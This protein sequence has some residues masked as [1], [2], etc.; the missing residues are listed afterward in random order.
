MGARAF[1]KRF[2]FE[3]L[4][5]VLKDT[6]LR[7]PLSVACC[8]A[9]AALTVLRVHEAKLFDEDFA[10]RAMLFLW[11]GL[12][13]FTALRLFVESRGL[14][15][16]LEFLLA[17]LGGALLLALSFLPAHFS[18]MHLFVSAALSL[19][20]LF[21]PYVGRAATEDSVWYYNYLNGIS[22]VI[23]GLSTFILCLGLCAVVGSMD[24]LIYGMKFNGRVYGDIWIFGGMFFG[25]LAFM[26][27]IPRRFDF[28]KGECALLP[29]VHFI[30]NYLVVPLVLIYTWVLYAYFLKIAVQWELPK[31]QLAYMVTGFGA[32]GIAAHLAVFPM[33]ETG[34]ML[35]RQFHRYFYLLLIVPVIL[36]A[37]GLY[38]RISQ[39]G[40]TEERYTIG[41][42][43][44]WLAL[45]AAWHIAKPFRAHIKHV[46]MVLAALFLLAAAGPWGAVN[47]STQS[48]SARLEALLAQAGVLAQG[49]VRKTD[50]PVPFE[51]RK[52]ISGVL[53]YM[54]DGKE[55]AVARWLEPFRAGI[56]EKYKITDSERQDCS[57][58]FSGC[59]EWSYMPERL[60]EAWGMKYVS[61]W[62]DSES[63]YV[64]ISPANYD[65]LE[66]RILRVSPYAY[67][68]RVNA[69]LHNGEWREERSFESGAEKMKVALALSAE[70][71]FTL[72]LAD[73]RSAAFPLQPLAQQLYAEKLVSVPSERLDRLTLHADSG[74]FPAEAQVSALR[75]RVAADQVKLESVTLL[76]L[77]SP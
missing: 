66:N 54:F 63:D 2:Q 52:N 62:E 39:Y 48:Q 16:A 67:M 73:G 17:A 72:T 77:F 65:A 58:K 18:A 55:K 46:P 37:I 68:I 40:V 75:G 35:L 44:V 30:A 43:L 57:R 53:D 59:W 64:S 25:P 32:A 8:A 26:H 22:L 19:S 38:T 21:A 51:L 71:V 9:A 20:M 33:R 69:Y 14:S 12:V 29:G 7:F 24:Y 74:A 15:R 49:E 31:G 1:L 5:G 60:M 6:S 45:L 56:E 76:V 47:L 42:A 11:H 34:T 13:F 70:G 27:Q 41:I 50:K 3:Y 61:R 10:D 36:L 23:A 28:E 4:F